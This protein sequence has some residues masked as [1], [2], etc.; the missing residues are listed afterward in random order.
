M[1]DE[2]QVT[3]PRTVRFSRDRTARK[4]PRLRGQ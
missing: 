1:A 4:P 2:L 3:L